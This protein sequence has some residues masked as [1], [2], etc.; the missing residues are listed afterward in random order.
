MSKTLKKLKAAL[1]S[2]K[3]RPRKD[4]QDGGEEARGTD[5]QL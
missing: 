1:S 3:R 5:L 2:G 4:G